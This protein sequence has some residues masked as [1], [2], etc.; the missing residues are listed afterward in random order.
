[1]QR[2]SIDD[3]FDINLERS[4]RYDHLMVGGGA[5]DDRIID[6]FPFVFLERMI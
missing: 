6:V 1:M 3:I 5:G 2:I 4:G